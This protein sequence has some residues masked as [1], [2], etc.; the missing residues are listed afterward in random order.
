MW[1][2]WQITFNP[3]GLLFPILL[4]LKTKWWQNGLIIIIITQFRYRNIDLPF[5][6]LS[7][8]VWI[9]TYVLFEFD[10]FPICGI[11]HFLLMFLKL[12][13]SILT[14]IFWSVLSRNLLYFWKLDCFSLRECTFFL[15]KL[16]RRPIQYHHIWVEII[17]EQF[18]VSNWALFIISWKSCTWV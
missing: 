9:P 3:F 12:W 14:D 7:N 16:L 11:L 2:W 15:F 10:Y 13:F 1:T 4:F 17:V 8:E 18:Y 6:Y 5:L